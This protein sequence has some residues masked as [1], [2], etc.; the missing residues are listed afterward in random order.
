MLW[1]NVSNAFE[2]SENIFHGISPKS[3]PVIILSIVCNTANSIEWFGL[4][5]YW[6]LYIKLCSKK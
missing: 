2:R 3:K 5:P 6:C 4:K 1:S